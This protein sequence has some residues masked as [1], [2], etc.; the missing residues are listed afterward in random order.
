M[1][2]EVLYDNLDDILAY[3]H[4]TVN[5]LQILLGTTAGIDPGAQLLL[6]CEMPPKVGCTKFQAIPNNIADNEVVL[7]SDTQYL[8]MW[9]IS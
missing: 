3:F 7:S 9:Y 6:F 5:E 2:R 4:D 8:K 1:K